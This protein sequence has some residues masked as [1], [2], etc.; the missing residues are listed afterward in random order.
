LPSP[1]VVWGPC[2]ILE[3]ALRFATALFSEGGRDRWSVVR[4]RLTHSVSVA[5][6]PCTLEK[7][8]EPKTAG[9]NTTVLRRRKE[10]ETEGAQSGITVMEA[11]FIHSL[12]RRKG[13]PDDGGVWLHE[14]SGSR[15]SAEHNLGRIVMGEDV[16]SGLRS[17][18]M[19]VLKVKLDIS[20]EGLLARDPVLET[21]CGNQMPITWES[22]NLSLSNNNG[23]MEDVRAQL[24]NEMKMMSVSNDDVK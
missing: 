4:E 19:P 10:E 1:L 22:S 2:C 7:P 24:A 21:S 15:Q 5:D 18:V 17:V 6:S 9:T 23:T 13:R 14:D 8:A 16:I 20:E 11:S 3:G 12:G